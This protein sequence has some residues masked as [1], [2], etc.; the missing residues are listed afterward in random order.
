MFLGF[1]VDVGWVRFADMG[2]FRVMVQN[3][4]VR[5]GV[6]CATVMEGSES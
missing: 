3:G 4:S 1:L 5:G 2:W 6:H